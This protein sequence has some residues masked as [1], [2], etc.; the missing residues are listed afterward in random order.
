MKSKTVFVDKVTPAH[1]DRQIELCSSYILVKF[2][3]A[4]KHSYRK[5]IWVL[6]KSTELKERRRFDN[7]PS[8]NRHQ[9]SAQL[10]RGVTRRRH[11]LRTVRNIAAKFSRPAQSSREDIPSAWSK[12]ETRASQPKPSKTSQSKTKQY[13]KLFYELLSA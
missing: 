3:R 8:R 4:H 5:A 1:C 12:G 13:R 2:N 7:R 11:H 9:R 10:F 6:R